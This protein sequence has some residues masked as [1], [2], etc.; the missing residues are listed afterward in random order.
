MCKKLIASFLEKSNIPFLIE[1]N[2]RR[3]TTFKVGGYADFMVFP[4]NEFQVRDVSIFCNQNHVPLTVLGKGSNV[5]VSDGGIKGTVL[6]LDKICD[7]DCY[8]DGTVICG[9]GAS[10][11]AL[12]NIALENG[13]SGLEFAYGI[14]GSVGG[15]VFMNA[16]AYGGEI[17]DVIVSA[18]VLDGD[19]IKEIILPDMALDYRTSIFKTKGL[20]II[21]ATF[22]LIKGVKSEIKDKMTVLMQK[23]KEKQ[24]LEFPSAGSTFKRPEGCFAGTLIEKSGLKGFSIGGAQVSN[25]H[26]GFVINKQNATSNDIKALI[27]YIQDKVLLDSGVKL[28]REVIYLGDED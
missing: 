6:S 11:T 12:C 25:K 9:A 28:E 27:K 5:L 4:E 24:P 20:I 14:P 15:A 19:E 2:M 17:K 21:S 8:P 10:L 22:R 13:L 18:K 26:A 16:G 1:E 7:I 23:R 3:R